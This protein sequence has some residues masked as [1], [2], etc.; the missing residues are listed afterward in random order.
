MIYISILKKCFDL[1][2]HV[3]INNIKTIVWHSYQQDSISMTK[4][5]FSLI[6]SQLRVISTHFSVIF[7]VR[8]P[9]R[10]RVL[11]I[12]DIYEA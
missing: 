5:H 2:L 10:L 3:N 4:S 6:K 9:S 7:A 8:V 11:H 1:P 12:H